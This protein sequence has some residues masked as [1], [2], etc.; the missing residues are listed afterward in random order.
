MLGNVTFVGLLGTTDQLKKTQFLE[1]ISSKCDFKWWGPKGDLINEFP[2]LLKTWQG[3]VAGK[4]MCQI[5]AH[6][7]IND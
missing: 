1:F 7:K 3:I 5:Y 2:C 6:S 4:E